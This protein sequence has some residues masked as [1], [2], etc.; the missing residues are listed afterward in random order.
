[1]SW[2]VTRRI[3]TAWVLTIPV[4]MALASGFYRAFGYIGL[5]PQ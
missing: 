2:G 3:A 5:L 4:C 1:V